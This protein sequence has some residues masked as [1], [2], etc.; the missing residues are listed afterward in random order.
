MQWSQKLIRY[1]Y[2]IKYRQ[3]KQAVLPDILSHRD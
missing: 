3:G 1:D 2:D